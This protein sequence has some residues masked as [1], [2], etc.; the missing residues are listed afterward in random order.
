MVVGSE[1]DNGSASNFLNESSNADSVDV[2]EIPGRPII[3][4]RVS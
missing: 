4:K 2:F 3:M 1:T